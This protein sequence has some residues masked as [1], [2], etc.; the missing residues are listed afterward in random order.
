MLEFLDKNKIVIIG[1][2]L[3]VCLCAG[4]AFE[5]FYQPHGKTLKI[6]SQALE[7]YNS[8]DYS[9]AYY[10]FSRVGFFSKLK[11]VALYR[12]ALCARA[13]GDETSEIDAYKSLFKHFPASHLSTEAKYKTAQLISDSNPAKAKQ[14]FNEVILSSS[15]ED[16]KVASEYYKS[17]IESENSK[18]KLKQE[19]IEKG[20]RNYLAKYPNG[21][22]ALQVAKNWTIYHPDMKSSDL[23]LVGRAYLKAGMYSDAE[24]LLARADIQDNWAVEGLNSYKLGNTVKGNSLIIIGVSKYAGNAAKNDYYSAADAYIQN[25]SNPYDAASELL[26]MAQGAN[27]DYIWNLKCKNAPKSEKYGCY[28]EFYTAFPN[29]DYAQNAMI[30][31]MIGRLLNRNYAGARIIADD[32]IIKYPDSENLDMVMFWR[33]KIEQKYAHNPSYDIFYRNVINNFPDSYFAYRAFWI[34][35]GINSS[36]MNANLEYKAIEYPYKYPPKGSVLYNLILVNDYDMM[37]KYTNDEFIKSWIQYKKGDYVASIYTA[38]KAMNKLKNKPPKDDP[39]WRLVYP[40]HYFKQVQNNA[41]HYQNDAALIMA[42]IREESHFNPDAQ[43]GVGAVGLMQLMPETAHEVGEKS[44][45]QFNTSDLFNPELNIKIGNIYYSQ[46]RTFFENKDISAI[47]AYNG[48]IG[49]VQKWK[50]ALKYSDTDEFVEQIPYDE[51]KNYVYKVM[52]SYWNYTRVY[53]K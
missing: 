9:N 38:Q 6:Y 3:A 52:K 29:G 32:F 31:S 10:L 39:R 43:S 25:S 53:Q 40:L 14:Y 45:Y 36:V 20:F 24:K 4:L 21:R 47:A 2:S 18:T 16:Y 41:G 37:N 13:L 35:Q 11:P 22:L 8:K 51:T 1:L 46:L 50:D 7:N 23:T 33:A 26:K 44:G 15:N 49:S 17:K 30:N 48:G 19:E 12:Q 42:I 34:V 5:H 28:E 27:K